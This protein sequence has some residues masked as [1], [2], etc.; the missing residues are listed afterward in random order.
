MYTAVECR[1]VAALP[2][3]RSALKLPPIPEVARLAVMI[4]ELFLNRPT[5]SPLLIPVA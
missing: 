2:L 3:L 1:T 5:V 4:I